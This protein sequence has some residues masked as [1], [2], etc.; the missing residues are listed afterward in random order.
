VAELLYHYFDEST[1]PFVNL[2]DLEMEEAERVLHEIRLTKKGFASQRTSDYVQIRRG[3]ELK[4]KQL[5][6]AK[7]GRPIRSYPHYMTVGKCPWLLDWYPLG[8]EIAIP[9]E[10][11][12]SGRISFT[13]GDLFPTMRYQ[14]GKPY[15]NQIYTLTEIK[16]VIREYGLP[17]Q[18]NS[19]GRQGP[20]RY[21]E[22]QIWEDGPLQI[23]KKNGGGA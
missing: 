7:G 16:E 2:S 21:I 9:V 12:D 13:Y 18:W 10:E 23:W 22:A 6:T 3:L 20:E 4:A 1:G 8:R 14:D 5:F 11:F 15:R 17:Q 19:D